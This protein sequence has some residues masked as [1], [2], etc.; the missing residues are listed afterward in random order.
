MPFAGAWE[1]IEP[2]GNW[3]EY[4]GLKIKTLRLTAVTGRTNA[5]SCDEGDFGLWLLASVGLVNSGSG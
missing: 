5:R 3:Q 1:I 4:V 2:F